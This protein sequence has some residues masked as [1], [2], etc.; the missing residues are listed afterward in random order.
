M[1]NTKAKSPRRV[2]RAAFVTVALTT[3]VAGT[4]AHALPYPP[5][6][7]SDSGGQQ[8]PVPEQQGFAPAAPSQGDLPATGNSD[9]SMTLVVGG[10]ALLLG[11]ALTS[12]SIVSNRRRTEAGDSAA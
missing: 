10:V 12:G 3:A 8:A 2:L 9:M 11:A 7:E 5:G 1:N 4:S 6:D